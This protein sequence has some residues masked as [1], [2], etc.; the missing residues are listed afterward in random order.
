VHTVEG[1]LKVYEVQVNRSVP[2]YTLLNYVAQGEDLVN[3][4]SSSSKPCLFFSELE[5]YGLVDS[6]Q[7]DY[8]ILQMVLT[9]V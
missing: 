7:K 3:T 2:F 6:P 4:S 1:L 8:I 9:E 5:V